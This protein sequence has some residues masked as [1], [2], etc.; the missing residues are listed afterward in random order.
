MA[1]RESNAWKLEMRGMIQDRK[2]REGFLRF[3]VHGGKGE[4]RAMY[5]TGRHRRGRVTFPDS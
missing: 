2:A 3:V 5:R 1:I 4:R